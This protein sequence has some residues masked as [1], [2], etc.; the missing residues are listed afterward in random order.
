MAASPTPPPQVESEAMVAAGA[1]VPIDTVVP[2]GE[3]WAGNPARRMR[4][5]KP[6]E[7]DYLR[8]LPKRYQEL[9]AQ[10]KDA[11]AVVRAKM[12]RLASGVVDK[13]QQ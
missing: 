12:D 5:L 2:S 1:V 11:L 13:P 4:D 9:A 7:L 8:N 6:D 10:H 3:L